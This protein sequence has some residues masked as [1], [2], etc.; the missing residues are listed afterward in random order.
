[1][2]WAFLIICTA[3]VLALLVYEI[4]AMANSHE[5]DTIS[6]Y[7]WAVSG[8]YPILPFFLGVII[9]TLAGHFWWQRLP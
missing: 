7:F 9:G 6:E 8:Q 5:G 2:V 1:M 3:S 4:Y